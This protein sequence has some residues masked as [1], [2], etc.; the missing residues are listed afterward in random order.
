VSYKQKSTDI[1]NAQNSLE[2]SGSYTGTIP[3][4]DCEGIEARIVLNPD[5]TYQVSYTYLGKDDSPY[6]VS[7]KFTWDKNGNMITLD[8]KGIPPYYFIGENTL[9]QL[10]MEGKCIEGEHADMY[11]LHKV[12]E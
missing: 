11:L 8:D 4:T 10:D 12:E 6:I 9:Q 7:G 5:E 3:C 1:H 2:W